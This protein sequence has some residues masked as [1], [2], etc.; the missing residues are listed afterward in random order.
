MGAGGNAREIAAIARDITRAGQADFEFAGFIV[1][2][3]EQ[4]G[5]HHDRDSVLGDF[6]CLR[7]QGIA[8]LAMGC[9]DPSTKLRLS[10]KLCDQFPDLQWLV[11]IHSTLTRIRL[12]IAACSGR[13]HK[14]QHSVSGDLKVE[15]HKTVDQQTCTGHQRCQVR[16]VASAPSLQPPSVEQYDEK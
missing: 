16:S 8:A 14:E 9:G 2:N 4:F 10:A 11:L 1:S 7:P 13:Q 6:D 5:L 3:M 12:G 15:V